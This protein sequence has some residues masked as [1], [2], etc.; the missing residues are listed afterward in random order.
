LIARNFKPKI[1]NLADHCVLSVPTV[2]S[3]ESYSLE[4][5]EPTEGI[6]VALTF[7]GPPLWVSLIIHA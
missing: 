7:E 3:G 1:S 5:A 4:T 6:V 2:I